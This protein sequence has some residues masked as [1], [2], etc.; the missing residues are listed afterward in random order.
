MLYTSLLVVDTRR[1]Q[2]T[3]MQCQIDT[4]DGGTERM[5]Q[6]HGLANKAVRGEGG[7]GSGGTFWAP[8]S[9]YSLAHKCVGYH[10]TI[11]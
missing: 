10:V 7:N 2:H 6:V 4:E 1:H 3:L 8:V 9:R 5:G 11:E